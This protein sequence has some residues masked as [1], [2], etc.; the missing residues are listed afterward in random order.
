MFK[1]IKELID[2]DKSDFEELRPKIIGEV[3]SN[4]RG[5]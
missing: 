1:Q 5:E 3:R 2:T 4:D